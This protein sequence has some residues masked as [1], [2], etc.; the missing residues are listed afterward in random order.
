MASTGCAC[1]TTP[2]MADTWSSA[3]S[4]SR[5]EPPPW[6]TTCST[7]SSPSSRPASS[8]T[9]RTWSASSSAGRR[10]NSKC[11]VRL[12]IVGSTFCGSVVQ[13]MNTTWAG[14]S[15]SDFSSA[16]A[17]PALSM[18]TSSRM[19]T[20]RLP[21]GAE[22]DALDELADVGDAV[23]GGGVELEQPVDD[24]ALVDRHAVGAGAVGLAVDG[25]LA[26]EDLGEDAGGGRLAGAARPAEQVGV[27]DPVLGAPRCAAPARRGP[28]PAARRSASSG[29]AGRAP[30][31]GRPSTPT[32]LVART[33]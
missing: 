4:V 23:V 14:G 11:W 10:W 27:A 13:R 1:S 28:G 12:R 29:T 5:A 19:T 22:R 25:L 33:R 8:I 2:P 24:A 15:S 18:W 32:L 26:V 7:A 16:L 20:L 6:R 17:A 21:G 30:G 9:Y 31:T 3:D